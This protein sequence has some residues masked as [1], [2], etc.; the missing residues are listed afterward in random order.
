VDLVLG[1]QTRLVFATPLPRRLPSLREVRCRPPAFGLIFGRSS[2]LCLSHDYSRKSPSVGADE[3]AVGLSKQHR[4]PV[5]SN[6]MS[7]IVRAL[8]PAYGQFVQ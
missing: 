2:L 4:A 1:G 3:E 8:T 5:G 7:H 6:R